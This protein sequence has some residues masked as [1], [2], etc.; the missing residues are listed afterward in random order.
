M[1]QSTGHNAVG[2]RGTP[3]YAGNHISITL[4]CDLSLCSLEIYTFKNKIIF[5]KK[6]HSLYSR[7]IVFGIA[8]VLLA[9]ILRSPCSFPGTG[10]FCPPL[11]SVQAGFGNF[12]AS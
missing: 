3:V 1:D 6:H 7:H 8:A 4:V 11:R 2:E 10:K 12:P 9:G 5:K